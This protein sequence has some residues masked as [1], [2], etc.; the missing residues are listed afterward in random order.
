MAAAADKN[1][2]SS[3]PGRRDLAELSALAD[4]TLDATR[5][6]AVQARV[7]GSVELS[8]LYA[9]ERRVVDLVRRSVVEVR[10][11][12][13]LRARIDSE[14]ERR[15]S[16]RRRPV[17]GGVLVAG[18]AAIVLMLVLVLPAGTPG[19]PSVSQAAA[20]AL[21]GAALPAP[22]ADPGD[23]AGKL[24][25]RVGQVYF[26][27]WA[28]TLGWR[29]V[30]QR[31]DHLNG[32]LAITVYYEWR[33]RRIAYTVLAAPALRQPPAVVS[34]VDGTELRTLRLGGRLVVTWRRAGHTCVLSG[35]GVS[36]GELERLAAWT[37]AGT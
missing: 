6:A 2:E 24:G 15:R 3:E 31:V 10:A 4:G 21:R 13:S 18:L 1:A 5:R 28:S 12:A 33:G 20:L 16:V 23:P 17:Y 26:P 29:A 27:N 32:R 34:R 35:A 37:P 25:R 22:A 9:R 30:G 11:P 8:E 14:V 36:A 19:A 7:A